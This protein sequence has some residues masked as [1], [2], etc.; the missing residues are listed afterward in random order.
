MEFLGKHSL[1]VHPHTPPTRYM[2][3]TAEVQQTPDKKFLAIQYAVEP[4]SSV[5]FPEYGIERT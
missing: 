5:S 4:A 2:Q 1:V 3:V